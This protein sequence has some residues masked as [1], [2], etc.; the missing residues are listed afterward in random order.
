MIFKEGLEIL[1]WFMIVKDF[2]IIK[3]HLLIKIQNII[4][5]IY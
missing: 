3:T 5:I 1:K 4:I 2:G